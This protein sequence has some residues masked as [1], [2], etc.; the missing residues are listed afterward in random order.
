MT[1]SAMQAIIDAIGTGQANTALEVRTA[2]NAFRDELWTTEKREQSGS[3]T[4]TILNASPAVS[5]LTY[6]LWFKKVGN[7]VFLKGFITNGSGSPIFGDTAI[8]NITNS[9]YQKLSGSSGYV[10]GILASSGGSSSIEFDGSTIKANALG[11]DT[12]EIL[13][14][15]GTYTAN[16]N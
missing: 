7:T 2:Y 15:N 6:D 5:G 11:L 8:I 13:V 4:N 12:G 10:L 1:K 14:V 3:G 9:V 16:D